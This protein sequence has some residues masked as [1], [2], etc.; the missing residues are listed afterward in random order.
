MN[1]EN[2]KHFTSENAKENGVKGGY[3]SGEAK[4]Q[5]KQLR[6]YLNELLASPAKEL[7][8]N[9]ELSDTDKTNATAVAVKTIQ[10]A[11]DGNVRALRLLY[12]VLGELDKNT[13]NIAINNAEY[14]KGYQ[15]GVNDTLDDI[16]K[17][18]DADA[19]CKIAGLTPLEPLNETNGR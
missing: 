12:D 17:L 14:E 5:R 6:E 2:L 9:T 7:E 16:V 18:L 10:L 1:S 13:I 3:A 11:K 4:R 15:Q 19:L 8:N